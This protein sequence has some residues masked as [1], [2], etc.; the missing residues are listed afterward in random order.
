MYYEE[1]G[2][3]TFGLVSCSAGGRDYLVVQLADRLL[4]YP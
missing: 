3:M 2:D 1:F 4:V